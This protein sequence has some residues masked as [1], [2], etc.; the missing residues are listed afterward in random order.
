MKQIEEVAK[1][2]ANAKFVC[3]FTGAGVSKESGIPTFRGSEDSVYETY[4]QKMLELNTYIHR[5]EEAW[6]VVNKVFYK[7]FKEAEPNEAHKIIAKWE[8][9]N[10]VKA[11]ITQNI[12]S[13]HQSAGNKNVVEFHGG[14]SHFV[15]LKC[16]KKHQT[17]SLNLTDEVPRC[18]CEGIL[19]PGF[20]FFGEGIPEDAYHDS[21][22]YAEKC[23]VMLIIGT[24][25]EV[26]PAAYIP[27]VAKQNGATIIE[28]NPKASAYTNRITDIYLEMGA[29][30]AMTKIDNE[31]Q[32]L[33]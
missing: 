4:D 1:A 18:E 15:C 5:T 17:S 31:I 2:I 11:V 29:V 26:Q 9:E 20:I 14:K 23:D 3:V 8:H 6:L 19:K 33:K 10:I 32:K 13:L 30:E 21:F 24:S 28:I 12:D 16:G 22:E 7:F 25:G 27:H